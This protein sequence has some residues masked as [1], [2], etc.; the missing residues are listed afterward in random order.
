V[1]VKEVIVPPQLSDEERRAA[2][3]RV[4]REARVAAGLAHP[5]AVTVYDVL[6]EDGLTYIVMELVEAPSLDELVRRDGPLDPD[7]AAHIG[8]QVLDVLRA[9]NAKGIVHR[10]VKPANVMIRGG[11][12]KLADFGIASVAGDPRLTTAGLVLGSPSFMSPEQAHGAEVGPATDL[13]SLG[14]TMYF[15]VEGVS[16]FDRGQTIPTLTAI[17]QEEP[18]PPRRAGW[19]GPVIMRLLAKEPA[20]RP[21]GA[22]LADLLGG[23]G[24]ERAQ[25]VSADRAQTA[26]LPAMEAG[27]MAAPSAPRTTSA[28]PAP[29]AGGPVPARRRT[30]GLWLGVVATA[31]V[32]A[33]VVALVVW[34]VGRTSSGPASG[35]PHAGAS[36]SSR[37]S[38]TPPSPKPSPTLQNGV[39]VD[40]ATGYRITVP[41]GWLVSHPLENTTDFTEPGSPTHL[42]VQ[43]TTDPGGDPKKNWE[44][45]AKEFAKQHDHYRKIEITELTYQGHRAA[46]WEFTY[47][48]GDVTLHAADLG[49][50]TDRYGFALFFQT[51]EDR[52]DQSQDLWEGF[53]RSFSL[54]S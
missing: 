30:G 42:R 9:A 49:F 45:Y 44:E 37:P 22:E 36:A 26:R 8:R 29:Q 12:V 23:G 41:Q 40:P 21:S 53:Q 33:L 34:M 11:Q 48:S 39:Y 5:G 28:L 17:V 24:A 20:A 15:A 52:W 13:W 32:A 50:V 3:A 19:L 31:A 47:Q 16:P 4:W 46:I 6:E 18:P 51:P 43:W 38:P 35:P 2:Q 27:V 10:D 25:T 54:P 14:A 7:G 1:A